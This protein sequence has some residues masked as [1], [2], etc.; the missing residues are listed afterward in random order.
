[1]DS[2]SP[3]MPSLSQFAIKRYYLRQDPGALVAHRDLCGGCRVTGVPTVTAEIALA[4][5]FC[6]NVP[7]YFQLI[8]SDYPF[9][10][11]PFF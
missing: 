1:M 8:D 5:T 6:T 3:Y 11:D 2:K 7:Y 10:L 9:R 4:S